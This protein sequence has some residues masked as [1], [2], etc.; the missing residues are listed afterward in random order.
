MALSPINKEPK[1]KVE[2]PK[3]EVKVEKQPEAPKK[4]GPKKKKAFSGE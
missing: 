2:A 3:E 4:R 1:L